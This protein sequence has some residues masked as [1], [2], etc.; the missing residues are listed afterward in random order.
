MKVRYWIS[1]GARGS[2]SSISLV[3]MRFLLNWDNICAKMRILAAF[4][5]TQIPQT[6][7]LLGKK[8]FLK[9]L[10]VPTIGERKSAGEKKNLEMHQPLVFHSY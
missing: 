2:R 8:C 5:M 3:I 10:Y 4:S 6:F 7:G 9:A 1:R